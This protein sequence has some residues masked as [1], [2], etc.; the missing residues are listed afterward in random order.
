MI[1]YCA[2]QV[3]E[4]L[5]RALVADFLKR[6]KKIASEDYVVFRN[7]PEYKATSLYLGIVPAQATKVVMELGAANYYKRPAFTN[8]PEGEETW[9]FGTDILGEQLYVK[10]QI[11]KKHNKAICISFH[12]ATWPIKYPLAA[13]SSLPLRI[14]NIASRGAQEYLTEQSWSSLSL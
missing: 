14:L 5:T 3:E 10:L 1:E 7:R 12:I 4:K 6:F 13:T 2:D 11:N 8:G 9:E